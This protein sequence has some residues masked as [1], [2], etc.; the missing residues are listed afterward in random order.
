MSAACPAIASEP[1]VAVFVWAIVAIVS[2]GC[3]APAPHFTCGASIGSG[4]AVLVRVAPVGRERTRMHTRTCW[5]AVILIGMLA[6]AACGGSS[7][8]GSK[9][10]APSI[11]KLAATITLK[12]TAQQT[13]AGTQGIRFLNAL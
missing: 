3:L 7:A 11:G 4:A 1:N 8:Q 13:A 5:S 12:E 2:G 9:P 6:L 10:K